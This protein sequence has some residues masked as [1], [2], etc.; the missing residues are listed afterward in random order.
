MVWHQGV[1]KVDS[2]NDCILVLIGVREQETGVRWC[3]I[4]SVLVLGVSNGQGENI[5]GG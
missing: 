4:A 2:L 3:H 5:V 1:E